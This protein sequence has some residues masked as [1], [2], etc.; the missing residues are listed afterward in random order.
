MYPDDYFIIA[1]G[2]I[3]TPVFKDNATGPLGNDAI[4]EK[5]S[6]ATPD[7]FTL[8]SDN[9]HMSFPLINFSSRVLKVF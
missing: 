4:L 7:L 5:N 2:T 3:G 9:K 1:V 6:T 8:L